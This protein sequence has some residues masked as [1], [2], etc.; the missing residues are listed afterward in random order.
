[1]RRKFQEL[2]D[3]LE[4]FVLQA[5]HP[6]LVL[7]GTGDEVP[8]VLKSLEA[9]DA[10]SCSDLFFSFSRP[11]VDAA[12]YVTQALAGVEAQISVINTKR[13]QE[14]KSP[15]PPLPNDC[16]DARRQAP[17]RLLDAVRYLRGFLPDEEEHRLV[18]ALLPVELRDAAGYA[19]LIAAFVPAG[20]PQPWMAGVRFLVRD[21]RDAPLLLPA[22]RNQ[23]ASHVLALEVDF[24]AAAMTSALIR[25]AVDP[26]VP[27]A[28]RMSITLQLAMMD[29]AYKSYHKALDKYGLV[30]TYYERQ[31]IPSMQALCL[32]GVGDVLRATGR[33][34]QALERYQQ[35]LALAMESKSLAVILNLMLAAGHA[36]T[37]VGQHSEAEGYYQMAARVSASMLNPYSRCDALEFAGAAAFAQGRH[38]EAAQAWQD[39]EQIARKIEYWER[40]ESVLARKVALF[41]QTRMEV[42]RRTAEASLAEVRTRRQASRPE[43]RP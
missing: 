27:L 43:V 8:Y 7:C 31:G 13:T 32:L 6:M 15:Y 35:G 41:S 14:G 37:D 16:L 28:E 3:C 18:L 4:E 1:M 2:K 25:D 38:G 39:C 30:Y 22:L 36:A 21:S 29:Y 40:L 26:A 42:E 17:E 10:E 11:F 5:E 19:R 20:T 23:H 9:L 24:T 33:S 34:S 12:T